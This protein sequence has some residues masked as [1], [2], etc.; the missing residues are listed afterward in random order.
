[1]LSAL[2]KLSRRIA[3]SGASLV[4]KSTLPQGQKR[5]KKSLTSRCFNVFMTHIWLNQETANLLELF[6]SVCLMLALVKVDIQGQ[7]G[8]G[9]DEYRTS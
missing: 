4:Y 9:A 2:A 1:M 5:K 6:R 3:E 8:L 7:L